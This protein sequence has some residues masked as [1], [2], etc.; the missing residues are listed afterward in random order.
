MIT[1][2]IR[3]RLVEYCIDGSIGIKEPDRILSVANELASNKI[4]SVRLQRDALD[5]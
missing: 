1:R 2:V 5:M 4:L 3:L